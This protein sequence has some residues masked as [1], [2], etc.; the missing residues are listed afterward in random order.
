MTEISVYKQFTVEEKE[1]TQHIKHRLKIYQAEMER[2]R[3]QRDSCV[4]EIAEL[5]L[6]NDR[7]YEHL[8]RF[9]RNPPSAPAF[10]NSNVNN[11]TPE[12]ARKVSKKENEQVISQSLQSKKLNLNQLK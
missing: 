3:K 9:G 11:Q 2:L 5:S 4:E 6:Q 7:L 1:H 8:M 12:R 10:T